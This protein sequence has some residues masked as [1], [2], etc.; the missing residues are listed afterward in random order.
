MHGLHHRYLIAQRDDS[1]FV[2]LHEPLS[3]DCSLKL[4]TVDDAVEAR[5]CLAHSAA[6]VLGHALEQTF[7]GALLLDGPG[8]DDGTFFYDCALPSGVTITTEHLST[9]YDAMKTLANTK[10]RFEYREA[11]EREAREL[12]A[13]N[14]HKLAMIDLIVRSENNNKIG[15]Y[16]CGDFVDLCRGP[17]VASLRSI[18]IDSIRLYRVAGTHIAGQQRVGGVAFTTREALAAWEKA[19]QEAATRDHRVIGKLQQLFMFSD[20]SPGNVF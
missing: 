8:Q 9:L 1:K 2:G 6:H 19:R 18:R 20:H 14:V 13:Y 4:L 17:H 3:E 16:R 7:D 5:R 11:S 12:F 10:E 15:V